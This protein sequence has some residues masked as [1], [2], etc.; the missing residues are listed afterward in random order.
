[1][2][3]QGETASPNIQVVPATVEQAPVIA[4]LLGI[5]S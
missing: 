3:E 2:T 4:N 1:M 5:R